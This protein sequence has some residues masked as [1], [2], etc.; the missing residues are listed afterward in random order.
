MVH[1]GSSTDCTLQLPISTLDVPAKKKLTEVT[2]HILLVFP[3]VRGE[4]NLAAI[5]LATLFHHTKTREVPK[6]T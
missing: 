4:N 2:L 5:H 3:G 6:I 1:L